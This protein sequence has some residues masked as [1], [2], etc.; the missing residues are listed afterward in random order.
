VIDAS[1]ARSSGLWKRADTL[2]S[3]VARSDVLLLAGLFAAWRS[4]LQLVYWFEAYGAA[5]FTTCRGR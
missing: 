4:L 2:A 3:A 1:V 5:G